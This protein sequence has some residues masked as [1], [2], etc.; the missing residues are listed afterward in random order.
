VGGV[1]FLVLIVLP[2][3]LIALL[4]RWGVRRYRV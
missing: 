2:V 4:V 1:E 3:V